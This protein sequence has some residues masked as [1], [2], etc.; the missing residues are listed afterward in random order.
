LFSAQEGC[1]NYLRLFART[2]LFALN[3]LLSDF[4]VFRMSDS[5]KLIDTKIRCQ[6][7][8]APLL[9]IKYTK[10]FKHDLLISG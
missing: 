4:Y 9:Y 1:D 8:K 5:T 6:I 10:M 3:S 7:L 2:E